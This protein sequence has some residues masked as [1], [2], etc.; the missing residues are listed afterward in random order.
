MSMRVLAYVEYDHAATADL[1]HLEETSHAGVTDL[2]GELAEEWR[3]W[4]FG[5]RGSPDP[6]RE[7]G[8]VFEIRKQPGWPSAVVVVYTAVA[9]TPERL[10]QFRI[11][12][13][14]ATPAG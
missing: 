13:V 14:E 8:W 5:P 11:E 10:A 9:A 12:L 2:V 7:N 3:R 1:R 6:G 4:G